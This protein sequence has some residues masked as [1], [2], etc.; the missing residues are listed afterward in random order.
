MRVYAFIGNSGQTIVPDNFNYHTQE[1]EVLMASERP[2]GNYIASADGTWEEYTP[3][4]VPTNE[5]RIATLE[6]ENESMN[7]MILGLVEVI[8][9][10]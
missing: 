6:A 2:E 4:T 5:E 1:N 7:D 10:M 9:N 8:D 3:V